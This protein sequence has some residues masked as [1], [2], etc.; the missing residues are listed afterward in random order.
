MPSPTDNPNFQPTATSVNEQTEPNSIR[1]PS[2]PEFNVKYIDRSYYVEPV[3]GVDQYSGKTVKTGGGFTEKNKTIELTIKNQPFSR[4]KNENDNWI[5][6]IYEV[7]YKGH[8]AQDWR[9]IT[10]YA[11][12][13]LG[14]TVLVFGLGIEGTDYDIDFPSGQ[15]QAT[16]SGDQVDFQ[17]RAKIGYYC[18]TPGLDPLD[19]RQ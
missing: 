7:K 8:F 3:Y 14:S 18:Q 19:P 13:P 2:V 1:G 12:S 15:I 16:Y 4:Y 5:E 9:T 10:E 6:L 17:N 11:D